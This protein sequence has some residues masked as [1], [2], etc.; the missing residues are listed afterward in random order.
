MYSSYQEAQLM[1]SMCE[2]ERCEQ[3]IA[4]HD[5]QAGLL[6]AQRKFQYARKRL[7]KIEFRVGRTRYM[8]KKSGFSDILQQKVSSVKCRP[9]VKAYRMC[10]PSSYFECSSPMLLRKSLNRNA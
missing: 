3:E 10:V 2:A 4:L 5:A 1:Y 6:Q 8:V 9:V 7:T